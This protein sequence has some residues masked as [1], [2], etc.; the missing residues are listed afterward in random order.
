MFKFIKSLFGK[1][2]TSSVD[3]NFIKIGSKKVLREEFDEFRHAVVIQEV[4]KRGSQLYSETYIQEDGIV[5]F[6]ITDEN[7]KEYCIES[8]YFVD[9]DK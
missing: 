1:K 7:D 8:K 2:K 6:V 3:D 5:I 4:M 9:K